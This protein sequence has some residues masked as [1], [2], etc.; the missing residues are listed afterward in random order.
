MR[1]DSLWKLLLTVII[2]ESGCTSPESIKSPN[3]QENLVDK[4]FP[5][6]DSLSCQKLADTFEKKYGIPSHLLQTISMVESRHSPWAI[7]YKRRSFIF[8]T[9]QE[10]LNH[11][12]T[13]FS[14]S[15]PNINIGCM[16]V[17]WKA[18]HKHFS[19]LS[20]GFSPY[21]NVQYAA[22]LLLRLCTKFGSWEKA[23]LH[24][25]GSSKK[26]IYQ[27]K[28]IRLWHKASEKEKVRKL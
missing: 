4:H 12:N 3:F 25:N 18:H 14:Y 9:R 24:Y 17:N 16:Q 27:K 8:R 19:S 23:I 11:I 28:V 22:S 13:H 6:T 20:E 2:F 10:A 1:V 5:I 21:Y 15:I 26:H 7:N